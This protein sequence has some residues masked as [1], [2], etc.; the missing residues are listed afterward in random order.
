MDANNPT[1][2]VSVR[3]EHS[4]LLRKLWATGHYDTDFQTEVALLLDS[5]RQ[6]IERLERALTETHD[7]WTAETTARLQAERELAE[8]RADA[9][10]TVSHWGGYA[11][12]YFQEKHNLAG[13][14]ARLRGSAPDVGD[15]H[16]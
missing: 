11:G 15:Q 10:E 7:A 2:P 8:V 6:E 4:A 3:D 1:E 5:R 14:I 16:G 9:A 13:D 12:S